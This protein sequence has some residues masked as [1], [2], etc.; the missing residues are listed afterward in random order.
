MLVEVTVKDRAT[1]AEY[2]GEVDSVVRAH[3][4]R[5]LARG[6]KVIPIAGDWNPERIVVVE[7]G[8]FEQHQRCMNSPEYRALVPLRDRSAEMRSILVEGC[9]PS[10]RPA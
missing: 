6:G 2:V 8:S 5:Y 9:P 7:F 4:G 3:G 10:G 1:Y